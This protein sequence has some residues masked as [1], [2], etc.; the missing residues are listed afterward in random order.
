MRREAKEGEETEKAADVGQGAR[1][2]MLGGLI[3]RERK[4]DFSET[5]IFIFGLNGS[6][7]GSTCS[8][9]GWQQESEGIFK[10]YQFPFE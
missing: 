10:K 4:K 8:Q 9:P 5:K 3:A 2:K 7:E 1:K 6:N